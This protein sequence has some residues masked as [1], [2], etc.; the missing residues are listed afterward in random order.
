MQIVIPMS[1]FGERFRKAGYKI[2][3]PLIKV[4][5]K[6]MILHIMD[7]FPGEKNFI[8][9]CNQEHLENKKYNLKEIIKS[10][11]PSSKIVGIKKHKLGPVNAIMKSIN[12]LDLNEPTFVSYCDYMCN[13]NYKNFLAN[14]KSTKPSGCIITYSGFHPHMLNSTKFAYIKKKNDLVVK[15]R[16]KKSFT[17]NPMSEDASTGGYYFSSALKMKNA[18]FELIKSKEKIKGEYY[19]S[20]AFN[21]LIKKKFS[22][23]NYEVS[24]FMQWG[25]PEDLNDFNYWL[26]IFKNEKKNDNKRIFKSGINLMPM[27]G[28]G[29]RFIDE[30]F[31]IPKPL[32]HINKVPMLKRSINCLPSSNKNILV[33]R[34]DLKS[35][36]LIKK[37]IKKSI[38]NFEIKVLKSITS[39]QAMTV[40]E[41]VKNIKE[42]NQFITVG[43]VDTEVSYDSSMFNKLLRKD[44]TDIIV[45]GFKNYK[46]AQINPKMYGWVISDKKKINSVKVKIE[47]KKNENAHVITGVF[48]FR[49]LEILKNVIESLIKSKDKVNGEYY[50]DSCISHGIKKNYS[51]KLLEVRSYISWGTPLELKIYN[52]W[53]N[54]FKSCIIN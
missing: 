49:N 12:H 19:V 50:L 28:K 37:E 9:I 3:K 32:I 38:D 23:T 54:C 25:T 44:K 21:H 33:L 42:T 14:I 16:E 22:V 45:W 17:K 31:K 48:T 30:G 26:N 2:P 39:G 36:N 29:Q 35:L 20:L 40:Y 34:K 18:F 47:P 52:Y 43:A 27:A 11:M 13:W 7:M 53:L 10:Y 1:G 5:G 51:C 41:S 24:H 8:F 6:E 4:N 15:V 46:L